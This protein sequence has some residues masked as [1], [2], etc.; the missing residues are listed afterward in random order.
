M[1]KLFLIT[2][3]LITSI[4]AQE[5]A[6]TESNQSVTPKTIKTQHDGWYA[7]FNMGVINWGGEVIIST[8]YGDTTYD[9]D[10]EDKV[11]MLQVGYETTSENRIEFY[12]KTDS[13]KAKEENRHLDMYDTSTF[14]INYQW[15]ISSLSTD[16]LLPYIRV[17]IGFGS[18]E[19]KNSTID[20][21]AVEFDLGVGI[22]Y[23]VTDTIDISGGLY[24]RAIAIGNENSD[25]TI[26]S[27]L[28][29][30]E[31]GANYHF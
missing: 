24:R 3:L 25:N 27:A 9:V 19:L 8:G 16:K 10:T 21:D 31:V 2:L 6:N 12:Y 15:G 1:N 17:G 11:M 5:P 7:G 23:H 30:V 29:G 26:I 4:N 14:G 22:H 20:F 13:I 28:N 18:G